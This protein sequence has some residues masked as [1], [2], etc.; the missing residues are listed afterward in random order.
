MMFGFNLT[1][2]LSLLIPLALTLALACSQQTSASDM[3][4]IASDQFEVTD[5]DIR[6]YLNAPVSPDG[7]IIWG[8]KDRVRQAMRDLYTLKALDLE[9]TAA[10]V[11]TE[12][13]RAWIAYYQIALAGVR[14]LV[15]QKVEKMMDDIDWAAEAEEYYLANKEEFVLPETIVVQTL[16]LKT[17]SRSFLEA[18]NLASELAPSSLTVEQ[19]AEMVG[20]HT[21]DPGN[22][23]GVLTVQKGQTV[24]EFEEAAFALARRGDISEPVI[25]RFGVHVIQLLERKP[26]SYRPLEF[27]KDDI[28]AMLEQKRRGEAATFIRTQP[29]RE[30]A[31]DVIFH[32]QLIDQFLA[33]VDQQHKDSLPK[34][35]A[36]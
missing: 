26:E 13:E 4:L 3:V 12:E 7:Q 21:E 24:P 18:V 16:L 8:S 22:L 9:A 25:S 35:P 27:V 33:D 2:C 17:D 1:R 32:Q 15:A 6:L 14:K 34:M 28:I 31:G 29:D 5:Q 19:F 23:D 11:L 20:E 30:P 10:G 36:P